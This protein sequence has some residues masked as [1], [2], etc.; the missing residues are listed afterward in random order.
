MFIDYISSAQNSKIK[1]ILA[2]QEKSKVRK[3]RGLFIVE[4]RR[5][6]MNCLKGNFIPEE[7]YFCKDLISDSEI[8]TLISENKYNADIEKQ[9]NNIKL[10]SI[11]KQLYEKIAYRGTTEGMLA[12]MKIRSLTL[13]D[14]IIPQKPLLLVLESVEKPGNLGAVIRSADAA[15]IDAVIICDPLTDLYNPNLIRS[16]IGGI[17]T[18]KVATST[19]AETIKWLKD[20]NVSII[21]AQLQ[22][23]KLYYD[24]D[25]TKATAI[26][27]GA[28]DKGLSDEWRKASDAKIR[29]P[30]LGDL[31]S[32][33]VSV[34]AAILCYEAVR[35]RSK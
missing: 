6:F 14:L 17:F 33:N 34:S 2:L 30:M 35:Q 24:T 29:I 4:G 9:L 8:R 10:Y 23:S 28:E 27:V 22:D 3:E 1:N 16:S 21:T 11:T 32:L 31:D 5:E 19:T 18:C 7:I 20:N 25:M 13:K 12:V 15:G 26:V